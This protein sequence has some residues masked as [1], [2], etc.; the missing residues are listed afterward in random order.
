MAALMDRVC[1]LNCSKEWNLMRLTLQNLSTPSFKP[2]DQPTYIE[3]TVLRSLESSRDQQWQYLFRN[4]VN[5]F[6]QYN[7]FA[8]KISNKISQEAICS[9]NGHCLLM[10]FERN[11]VKFKKM[12]NF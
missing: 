1:Q 7:F 9:K 6:V 11:D 4:F 8:K 5:K 3:S 2:A 12:L 10:D